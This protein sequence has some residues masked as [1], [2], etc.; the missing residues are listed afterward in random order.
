MNLLIEYFTSSN[1]NRDAEYKTCIRENLNCK[2]IEKVIVFISDE[3]SKLDIVSEKLEIVKLG[4]RPTFKFLFEWANQNYP[5]QICIIGNTDIIFD[6][7]LINL[8]N[9]NFDKSFLALTRWDLVN[10]DNQWF[11]AFFNHPYRDNG[12]TMGMLSQDSWI[13]KT[14]I[15]IDERSNFLMGKPGC[16]N[17]IVAIYHELGYNV[18][19]PSKKIITKH[20]HTTNYRTYNHTDMVL[21]PYLLVEPTDDLEKESWKQI[22]LHF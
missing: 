20:L 15:Q 16:D 4:Q 22:I 8:K 2:T 5:E 3:T 11:M 13:F 1:S 6:D 7:S 18:K 19:N 10:R 17:R 9:Y 14:P 12:W 21:G